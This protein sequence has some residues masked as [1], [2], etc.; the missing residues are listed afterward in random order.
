MEVHNNMIFLFIAVSHGHFTFKLPVNVN[1][2]PLA[3]V[4]VYLTLDSSEV[5]ADSA[6]FKLE[7]CFGNKVWILTLFILPLINM[8]FECMFCSPSTLFSM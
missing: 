6:S 4:L 5:I 7:K 3:K 2:A 8:E 1:T